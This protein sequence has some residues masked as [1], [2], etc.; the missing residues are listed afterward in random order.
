[1]NLWSNTEDRERTP[2]IVALDFGLSQNHAIRTLKKKKKGKK[3]N[4]NKKVITG[5]ILYSSQLT[6]IF[7]SFLLNDVYRLLH[8]TQHGL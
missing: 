7:T 3:P 5:H 6:S 8:I 1:M 4:Q 2:Q